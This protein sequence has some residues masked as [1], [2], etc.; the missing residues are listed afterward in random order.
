MSVWTRAS[1]EERVP[2]WKVVVA[3]C[4]EEEEGFGAVWQAGTEVSMVLSVIRG[5]SWRPAMVVSWTLAITSHLRHNAIWLHQKSG[6]LPTSR[7]GR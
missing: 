3:S 1:N 2:M 6:P 5:A 7:W 4:G